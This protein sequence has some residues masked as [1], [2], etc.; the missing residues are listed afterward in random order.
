MGVHD[1]I[2]DIFN[3]SSY[4]GSCRR[5]YTDEELAKF[6]EI[7]RLA[8]R[9][10][11]RNK[12]IASSLLIGSGIMYYLSKREKTYSGQIEYVENNILKFKNSENLYKLPKV[13][14][15]IF[16]LII[17]E[18]QNITIKYHGLNFFG[19]FKVDSIEKF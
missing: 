1:I 10:A 2:Q 12:I 8:K 3:R 13:S 14:S 4:E 16:S 9:T 15:S 19:N 11:R 18:K 7:E 17:S 5:P 6:K